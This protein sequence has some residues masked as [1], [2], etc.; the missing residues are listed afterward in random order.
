[1]NLTHAEYNQMKM[2]V[3]RQGG[4]REKEILRN[5][6]IF[7]RSRTWNNDHKVLNVL[8]AEPQEDGYRNGFAVD[9]VAMSICGQY[10]YSV[11]A[12]V[13]H[14]SDGTNN[15]L[16]I[17]NKIQALPLECFEIWFIKSEYIEDIPAAI[18]EMKNLYKKAVEM[19]K[20]LSAICNAFNKYAVEGIESIY[21]DKRIY[22]R[23]LVK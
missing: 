22:E 10:T 18:A 14:N 2:I 5:P 16:L 21:C 13:K 6:H 7:E 15:R 11:T 23:L 20:E 17:D 4:F 8:E 9:L 12:G 3:Q 1:M 19:Q